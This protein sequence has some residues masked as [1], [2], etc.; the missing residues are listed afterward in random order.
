M[1]LRVELRLAPNPPRRSPHLVDRDLDTSIQSMPGNDFVYDFAAG[2]REMRDL[3]GGKGANVAE[4]TRVLGAE[5]VPAGFTITTESCVAFM[6][7]GTEPDGMDDQVRE[8]LD[9]LQESA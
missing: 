1:N 6:Q 9:R 8:A 3:L 5:R 2:S 7:E 4:M